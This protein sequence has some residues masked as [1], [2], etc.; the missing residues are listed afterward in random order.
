M[1]A[2]TNCAGCGREIPLALRRKSC[3]PICLSALKKS[4]WKNQTTGVTAEERWNV[5]VSVFWANVFKTHSCWFWIGRVQSEGYGIYG[6]PVLLAHHLSWRIH[7]GAIPEGE[8]VLHKCDTPP[9]VNPE[10][11]FLG[12]QK[13]NMADAA[14][15]GVV[16]NQH[17]MDSAIY[18]TAHGETRTLREWS[19]STGLPYI[20]LYNRIERGWPDEAIV[21]IT[22]SRSKGRV[23]P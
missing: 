18:L 9:C 10:H 17:G 20:T 4:T 3:G 5:I 14:A 21:S 13:I 16:G 1:D 12:N 8:W 15:K 22:N 11:L 19:R 7:F 23:F 2:M 6:K